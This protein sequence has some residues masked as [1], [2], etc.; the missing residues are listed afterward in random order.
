MRSFELLLS[1][2]VFAS[3]TSGFAEDKALQPGDSG[4]LHG[5]YHGAYQQLF[6]QGKC[7]CHTGECRPTEFRPAV[8]SASGVQAKVN[9]AWVD[10][11]PEAF[12]DRQSV[13]PELLQESAHICAY[14]NAAGQIKVECFIITGST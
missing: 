12:L 1:V 10:V 14:P 11:P 3:T 8:G 13:P 5:K 7:Y 2:S 9:G 6:A 4:Y